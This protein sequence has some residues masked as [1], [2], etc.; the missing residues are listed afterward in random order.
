MRRWYPWV[1][2]GRPGDGRPPAAR[3]WKH[4]SGEQPL[5]ALLERPHLDIG[6]VL[7]EPDPEIAPQ[8]AEHDGYGVALLV[9]QRT[10]RPPP[11]HRPQL[12]LV[13]EGDAV[14]DAV[15]VSA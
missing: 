15:P 1:S 6:E 13:V 12:R 10:A 8:G 4:A 11:Q 9:G 5:G 3:P 7:G 14:V 2:E